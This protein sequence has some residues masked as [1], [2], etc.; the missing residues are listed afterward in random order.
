MQKISRNTAFRMFPEAVQAL[1]EDIKDDV[2]D[3]CDIEITYNVDGND[4][5]VTTSD[6]YHACT[7]RWTGKEWVEI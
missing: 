3:G 6:G 2:E 4:L 1:D 7:T 5:V